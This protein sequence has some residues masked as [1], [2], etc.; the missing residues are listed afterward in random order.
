MEYDGIEFH[1]RNPDIVTAQNISQEYLE[2]DTERQLE[3]ENYG[4]KFLRINKFS[5]IPK[6]KGQT[7]VDVLSELLEAKFS[8]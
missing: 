7:K 8:D 4:Y 6:A 1:M 2:Y 3:L 5:L